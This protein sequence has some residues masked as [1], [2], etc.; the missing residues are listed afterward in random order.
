MR[1][2]PYA[3]ITPCQPSIITLQIKPIFQTPDMLKEN[4]LYHLCSSG[5]NIL[6]T[7]QISGSQCWRKKETDYSHKQLQA[8][9][10]NYNRICILCS[11]RKTLMHYNIKSAAENSKRQLFYLVKTTCPKRAVSIPKVKMLAIYRPVNRMKMK[12]HMHQI[13]SLEQQKKNYNT[14]NASS[15]LVI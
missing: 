15:L 3:Q 10:P 13:T 1:I 5:Q 8:K 2:L 12:I 11:D 6:K 4:A 9:C 14:L 7:E